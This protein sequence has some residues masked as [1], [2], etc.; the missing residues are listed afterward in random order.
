[1]HDQSRV[2]SMSLQQKTK[3]IKFIRMSSPQLR[4]SKTDDI[5]AEKTSPLYGFIG[6]LGTA[7][8]LVVDYS[9]YV[10]R[11]TGCNLVPKYSIEGLL[12][13]Q[14]ASVAL[15]FG[16]FAWSVSTK[17]KTGNGLPAGPA[18]LLGG[19]EGLSFLTAVGGLV[20]VTL[21]VAEYGGLTAGAICAGLEVSKPLGFM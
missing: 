7:A 1:M 18:G 10:V 11:T 13:E 15:V 20:V 3:P 8:A 12:L 5:D 21:N 16:I 2:H 6:G 14:A 19:A 4:M 17:I 9:L